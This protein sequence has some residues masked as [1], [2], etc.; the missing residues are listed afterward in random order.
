MKLCLFKVAKLDACIRPFCKFS[1]NCVHVCI[2]CACIFCCVHYNL[3]QYVCSGTWQLFNSASRVYVCI[4]WCVRKVATYKNC[5]PC[6][7]VQTLL[8]HIRMSLDFGKLT[9]MSHLI[10]CTFLAQLIAKLIHYPW[11]VAIPGLADWSA[12]LKRILL[13]TCRVITEPMEPMEGTRWEV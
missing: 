5:E 3:Y 2:R 4:L 10:N 13:T 6:M 11:T 8:V 1:H 9:E 7:R 12:F